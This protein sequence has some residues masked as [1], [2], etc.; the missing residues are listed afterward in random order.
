VT[1]TS[2]NQKQPKTLEELI[3]GKELEEAIAAY[4]FYLYTKS[5]MLEAVSEDT[6]QALPSLKEIIRNLDE[7][8]E[9]KSFLTNDQETLQKCID[10]YNFKEGVL[11]GIWEYTICK[12][13]SKRIK[14]FTKG[15]ETLGKGGKQVIKDL[16]N[17]YQ[18]YKTTPIPQEDIDPIKSFILRYLENPEGYGKQINKY[19][20]KRQYLSLIKQAFSKIPSSILQYSK[21]YRKAEM[22][23]VEIREELGDAIENYNLYTSS[24]I[25]A[26][27]TVYNA[28]YMVYIVSEHAPKA[29]PSLATLIENLEK[30]NGSNNLLTN[31][32]EALKEYADKYYFMANFMESITDWGWDHTPEEIERFAKG[33][34]AL[35]KGGKEIIDGLYRHYKK[36]ERTKLEKILEDENYQTTLPYKL[37]KAR[38]SA[39]KSIKYL[40]VDYFRNPREHEDQLMKYA[41]MKH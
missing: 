35:A 36:V 8:G 17:Q 10:E 39:G 4:A 25:Y 24:M 30:W 20:E 5:H 1:D 32:R 23:E 3:G 9:C 12:R 29:L 18:Q 11:G 2:S 21:G 38:S 6:P 33:L 28:L 22:G 7:F 40:L 13:T 14:E 31:D 41:G 26:F 15:L 27:H 16:Y 37:E 19:L 34:E